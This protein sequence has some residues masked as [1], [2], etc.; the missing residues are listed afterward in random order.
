MNEERLIFAGR[1]V[2]EFAA[3][4]A[5]RLGTGVSGCTIVD[6]PDGETSVKIEVNVRGRFVFIIQ[7]MCPPVN[8]NL[9]ELL[10]MLDAFKRASAWR[11]CAV[12]PYYGY[13]RQ[14]RKDQPRVPI[15]AKL[16]AELL[17]TAGAD[18]VL[19]MDLHAGQIQGF[20]DVPVD[21]LTAQPIFLKAIYEKGLDNITIASPDIGGV[22]PARHFA[23]VLEELA[24]GNGKPMKTH[25]AVVD[26]QR[27]GADDVQ[28]MGIVGEVKGR[29]VIIVDDM[30]STAGSLVEAAAYIKGEGAES[31]RA[32]ITHPLLVGESVERIKNSPLE[33]LLVTDTIPMSSEKELDKI[34]VCPVTGLF[35]EAIDAIYNNKSVSKLFTVSR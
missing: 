12:I 3:D 19:T 22:K 2:P 8:Q 5:E 16:V 9:V 18:R 17:T 25:F 6:F 15:T 26:K 33:E 23:L 32:A 24:A 35:A 10:I 13:A 20:F 34:T 28:A 7:S 4:V 30:V 11:V 1:S 31:V 27:R 21:N 14:D 29:N